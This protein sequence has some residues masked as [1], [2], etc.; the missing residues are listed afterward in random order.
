MTFEG[1]F[2]LG[3][4]RPLVAILRTDWGEGGLR[5]K[6][7]KLEAFIVAQVRGDCGLTSAVALKMIRNG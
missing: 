7:R 1:R 6:A 5:M 4:K 3:Y 2:D